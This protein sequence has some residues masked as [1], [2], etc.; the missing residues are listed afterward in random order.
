MTL[1]LQLKLFLGD[2]GTYRTET[3]I[4][5]RNLFTCPECGTIKVD[6]Q[7]RH[8]PAVLS[9]PSVSCGFTYIV[10]P[11]KWGAGK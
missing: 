5:H 10:T 3:L 2:R 4:E 11:R 1:G 9:C 7:N 6:Y 8:Q